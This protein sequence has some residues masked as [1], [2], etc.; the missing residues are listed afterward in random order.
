MMHYDNEAFLTATRSGNRRPAT[1]IRGLLGWFTIGAFCGG[2]LGVCGV[3]LSSGSPA[4]FTLLP[5]ILLGGSEVSP[6]PTVVVTAGCV[7]VLAAGSRLLYRRRGWVAVAALLLPATYSSIDLFATFAN[8]TPR[9][10]YPRVGFY[11][12]PLIPILVALVAVLA[13]WKRPYLR[14][15]VV[16]A[17]VTVLLVRIFVFYFVVALTGMP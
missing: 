4:L 2:L 15:A 8:S 16:A 12:L 3:A 7:L 6:W 11:E 10:I 13:L 9:T 5:S 17:C 1:R 14:N